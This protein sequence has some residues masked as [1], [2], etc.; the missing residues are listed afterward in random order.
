MKKREF[1]L[2]PKTRMS[3]TFYEDNLNE[4]D[5]IWSKRKEN[6]KRMEIKHKNGIVLKKERSKN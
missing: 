3:L 5:F 2:V 6:K 1:F 4:E